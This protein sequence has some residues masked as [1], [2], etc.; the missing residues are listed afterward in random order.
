M[1]RAQRPEFN[2]CD[3][4]LYTCASICAYTY[5]THK[6]SWK[7]SITD[8]KEI[9]TNTTTMSY[10][11]TPIGTAIIKKII[12]YKCCWGSK[13]ESLRHC[14]WKCKISTAIIQQYGGSEKLK[15]QSFCNSVI[16]L[17]DIYSKEMK[18]AC[19]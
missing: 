8:N 15:W 3:P 17:L 2:P 19:F 11:P 12:E 16:P 7:I 4:H 10:A 5:A 1:L 13:R 14:G 9:Q 6:I 18:S